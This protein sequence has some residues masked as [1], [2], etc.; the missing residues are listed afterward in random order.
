MSPP[1]PPP[2]PSIKSLLGTI[3][4]AV[5]PM[6]N[7]EQWLDNSAR[8]V[9]GS[10]P[11]WTQGARTVPTY[12]H[13]NLASKHNRNITEAS[14]YSRCIHIY[15]AGRHQTTGQSC[16][17]EGCHTAPGQSLILLHFWTLV[18]RT[19]APEQSTIK[20]TGDKNSIDKQAGCTH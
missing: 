11:R 15:S 1:P 19:A 4:R 3:A 14:V 9:Y 20:I 5:S 12:I 6:I 17:I 16:Q 13:N 8:P 2:P 7:I 18:G 10:Q